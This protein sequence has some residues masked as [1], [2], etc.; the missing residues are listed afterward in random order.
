MSLLIKNGTV[1]TALDERVTDVRCQDGK[2]AAIG[3]NLEKHSGDELID[4]SG[5]FVFPRTTRPAAK[6]RRTS[7]LSTGATKSFRNAEPDVIRTPAHAAER[8]LRRTGTPRK[9]PAGRSP[10]AASR[11][12]SNVG[13]TTAFRI[14]FARSIRSIAASTSS[15]VV[16][17][18]RRTS[19][20][21]AV[22]SSRAR[23]V[24]SG[25]CP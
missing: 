21:W 19:S 10:R 16:I 11:A 15:S 3:A 1:V 7:T 2:I 9:G 13:V 17:S 4:A 14:G 24:T 6:Y 5:Q 22:A 18:P 25:R 8:S 23:S 20:A 12:R